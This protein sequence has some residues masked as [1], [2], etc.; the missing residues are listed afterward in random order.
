MQP[1][2]TD[3]FSRFRKMKLKRPR[4]VG[5]IQPG[6]RHHIYLLFVSLVTLS[7]TCTHKHLNVLKQNL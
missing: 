4:I 3:T 7:Q 6:M 5:K 2:T 1:L